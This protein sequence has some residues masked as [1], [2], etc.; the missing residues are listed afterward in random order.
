M[1]I[2]VISEPKLTPGLRSQLESYMRRA[3]Y[4]MMQVRVVTD[5]TRGM[6]KQKTK[7]K[8]IANP[9][10]K[11][12]FLLN[13]K[14]VI[15]KY[16]PRV[17]LINDWLTL[18]YITGKHESLALT[19]GSTYF[20]NHI[21]AIVIDSLRT[22][23]GS[24]KLKAVKHAGWL[25]LQDLKKA[26]R[27]YDGETMPEPAF[28]LRVCE[29]IADVQALRTAAISGQLIATDIETSG[30]GQSAVITCVGF[31]VL[32]TEGNTRA[33]SFVVPFLHP[34][35]KDGRAWDDETFA[36]VL[37]ILREV[38]DCDTPKVLQN[39]MY[40]VQY[41]IRYRMPLRNFFCD[42]AIMFHSIWP[43]IPKRLDFIAS[44]AS[45]YYRYWKD[46]STESKAGE[47][48]D[49]KTTDRLPT[50]EEGWYKYL[51]YNGL[52]CHNTLV[53]CLYL[54]RILSKID[55]AMENYRQSLRQTLGPALAMSMRGVK[56]DKDLAQ[57]FENYNFAKSEA[58]EQT[59]HRMVRDK[60]FNPNSNPQVASLIY[61]V[62]KAT[63]LPKRG[64]KR[65]NAARSVGE[66]DLEIIKTQHPLFDIIIS[67]IWDVKKPKNNCSKYGVNNLKLMFDR[68][69]YKM[70]A[71]GTETARYAS[72]ASDFWVGTQIQNVPY[73]MRAIVT[74]DEGYVLFD[75]D[76]SKADFWHT[77][78]ASEEPNMMKV[79]QDPTLDT[80]CY[81]ASRFFSKP[82]DE[83][84]AGYKAKEE[85]VVESLHGVRQ[86]AKRIVY[87]ANYL[88]AGFTLFLTMGKEAVDATAKFMGYSTANWTF[89]QYANFCQSLLDF[90]FI[91]L[92]PGLMPWL[93][94]TIHDASR[95]GNRAVCCGNRTRTFFAS[96]LNNKAAQRELAAFFGQ[97]GT[98]STINRAMDKIYYS[99]FDSQDCMLLFQ[100]HD[101]IVGQVKIDKLHL[102]QELKAL[103][104]IENEINGHKFTIPVDGSV[105]LGWGYRMCDYHENI[106]YDEIKKADD[107]W[108]EN[109]Q[110]LMAYM[111]KAA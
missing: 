99:G 83:I 49:T 88:M 52:D 17:I 18:S 65:S 84:Y 1:T 4:P 45:D 66:K 22:Q 71:V 48:D 27:W 75:F 3:G 64:A 69:Y 11:S 57:T 72:K 38:N 42:T 86:N 58:A 78:F 34:L 74:P 110:E 9:E 19:R 46:E 12:Q 89:N 29:T 41:F 20:I 108:K 92:Y 67:Q 105:G 10:T 101:A 7:T 107:K 81:H 53:S 100:V 33:T 5:L 63:P 40:D 13:L 6:I 70:N 31:T 76:Y 98:A 77:A 111:Q 95:H 36:K 91:D 79:V 87:G 90:Y 32:S 2:L 37:E 96:L 8:Q 94:R 43:E 47:K 23:T 25:L 55:W 104:E 21:P 103:M 14:T 106:T 15:A 109:N 35:S 85:W 50:T 54:L 44:I 68:W 26:K 56:V 51:R 24:A 97:G 16:N 102:L 61:D 30:R 73:P 28:V 39:G 93:E 80:H 60:E 59:L 82:Y 62:L